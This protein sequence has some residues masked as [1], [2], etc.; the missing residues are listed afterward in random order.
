MQKFIN[1]IKQQALL[2]INNIAFSDV[3]EVIAFDPINHL[4]I[5]QIHEASDE[6]EALK[7][8]W[9]PICSPWVGNGWGMF[10]S[11]EIGDIMLVVYQQGD[12]S[13]GVAVAS[14]F[15]NKSRP[16]S[17]NPGEFYLIHKSGSTIK[18]LNDGNIEINCTGQV[19]I[20]E[21][22][23]ALKKLIKETIKDKFNN[24]THSGS[25]P[26]V[27]ESNKIQDSDLTENLTAT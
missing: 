17:V 16:V 22:S 11:V 7:T 8:G 24:H 3:G 15:T 23:G 14:F 1:Q 12:R 19:M 20:G 6:E 2:S 21:A 25:V 26:P 10:P 9:I 5:V 18:L 4:V 27:E 13:N